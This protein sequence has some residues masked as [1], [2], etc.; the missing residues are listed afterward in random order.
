L[1]ILID[2]RIVNK[3]FRKHKER[4]P[5]LMR[6]YY[7]CNQSFYKRSGLFTLEELADLLAD[8]GYK[9]LRKNQGGN[10]QKKIKELRELLQ[11]AP[12]LFIQTNDNIFR[13]VSKHRIHRLKASERVIDDSL[14]MK[15]NKREFFDLIIGIPGDGH[16]V[17]LKASGET[18][19]YT[20]AR[21]CQAAKAN[22]AKGYIYKINNEITHGSYKTR[23]EALFVRHKI[24]GERVICHIRKISGLYHILSF[25]ANSYTS[26]TML[27]PKSPKNQPMLSKSHESPVFDVI[28]R[29][30]KRT[31]CIFR[32]IEISNSYEGRHCCA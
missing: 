2:D 27:N 30:G 21:I 15:K 31:L 20:P 10:R 23:R 1:Q 26:T 28:A 9:S 29:Y 11:T 6:L 12:E 13:T 14:F 24:S 5:E 16:T 18:T 32:S 4:T 8:Q 25:G 19:G 22:D 3:T 17:D 7:L